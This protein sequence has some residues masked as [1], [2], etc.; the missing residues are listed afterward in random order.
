MLLIL[1]SELETSLWVVDFDLIGFAVV[2]AVCARDS[3]GGVV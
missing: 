2:D 3:G 1:A